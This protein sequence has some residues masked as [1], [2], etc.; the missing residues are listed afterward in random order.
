M[1]DVNC[2]EIVTIQ[3]F[4]GLSMDLAVYKQDARARVFTRVPSHGGPTFLL[5]DMV[6]GVRQKEP[7]NW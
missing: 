3:Y 5:F 4:C 7:A 6:L 2:K 1:L